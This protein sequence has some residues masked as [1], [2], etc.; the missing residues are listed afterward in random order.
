[1]GFMLYNIKF[2]YLDVKGCGVLISKNN[3]V[4]GVWLIYVKIINI[5]E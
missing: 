3:N 1:M 4:F 2:V 5:L